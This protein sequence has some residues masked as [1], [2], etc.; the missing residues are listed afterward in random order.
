MTSDQTLSSV[1]DFIERETSERVD[2]SADIL[3][4]LGIDGLDADLFF[5]AFAQ[6]FSIDMSDFNF[7]NYYTSDADLL[8]WPKALGQRILGKLPKHYFVTAYHLA[9]VVRRGKWFVPE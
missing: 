6:A 2:P 4:S 5:E 3:T 9:E 8:N 7:E 1:L